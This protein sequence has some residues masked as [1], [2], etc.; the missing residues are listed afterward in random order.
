M[1]IHAEIPNT[2]QFSNLFGRI[3]V[4]LH[5]AIVLRHAPED[6]ARIDVG[7]VPVYEL[8]RCRDVLADGLLGQDMLSCRKSLAYEFWL[9]RDWQSVLYR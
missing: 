5:V 9:N 8:L 4:L 6:F 7:F 2:A 1:H 3:D